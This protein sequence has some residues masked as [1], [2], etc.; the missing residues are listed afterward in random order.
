MTCSRA[1]AIA[2]LHR[3]T[4]RESHTSNKR[5]R[6]RRDLQGFKPLKNNLRE[7]RMQW[8]QSRLRPMRSRHSW[9]CVTVTWSI[10][11][12]SWSCSDPRMPNLFRS[13]NL[14]FLG[15]MLGSSGSLTS[16]L[17]CLWPSPP[18]TE[19]QRI[20]IWLLESSSRRSRHAVQ[21]NSRQE[22]WTK[23]SKTLSMS[24]SLAHWSQCAPLII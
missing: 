10:S 16:S 23:K 12:T 6:I 5:L 4:Q 14:Q 8:I 19:T 22:G 18:R 13:V 20:P 17:P 15:K 2:S 24:T 7:R 21:T 1:W 3:G 11:L 9:T